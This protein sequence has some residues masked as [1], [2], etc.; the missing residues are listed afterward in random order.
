LTRVSI[1]IPVL[2]KLEFT[3]QCLDRIWRNSGTSI[4]YEVIIIDNGSA[5]ET[6]RFFGDVTT[7]PGKVS[8][9]RNETNL[10]YARANNCAA[11]D[12]AGEYL[13]F[14][15][16]DTLVQEGWLDAMVRTI[17]ADRQVGIVGIKQLFPYTNINYHTGIVFGPDGLP[18]HLYPHLDASLERVNQTREYQAVTGACLLIDRALFAQCGGFD[19]GYVNGYEDVDLCLR[20]R[21]L[22]RKVM[23]CTEAY[24]YHY[25]QISEGRTSADDLNRAKFTARWSGRIKLDRDDYL[26]RDAFG[27]RPSTPS[28]ATPHRLPADAVYF[29]DSLE[30][31]SALTWMNAALADALNR[32]GVPVYVS[33]NRLS[34]TL[35]DDVR[36]R[37]RRCLLSAPPVGGTQVKWSHFWPQHL[38]LELAGNV[39]LELF[40]INYTFGSPHREPWDQWLQ[41]VARS[42]RDKLP[43]SGFCQSVLKQV[44]V[45]E[46]N[47]HV[48]SPGFSPEALQETP[49]RRTADGVRLLSVT[50]SHDLPRYG[51]DRVVE[52]FRLAFKPA[53][54]VTLVLKDYGASSGDRALREMI[55]AAGS[56]HIELVD[57]FTDKRELMR[58]YKSC[59]GFVSAHRGEG[60][61]MKILDA[62]ACGLP[63]ILPLFG[64]PT[65]YCNAENCY[66]VDFSLVPMTEGMDARSLAI[67]NRPQWA[68]V[69]VASLAA[70]M[71]AVCEDLPAAR[72]LG[73]RTQ[74]DVTA[75]FTWDRAAA[76]LVEVAAAICDSRPRPRSPKP[77]ERREQSPYWLGLRVSVVIPTYNRRDKLLACLDALSRQ[78]VLPQEFE[79]LV[80]DDG[81]SDGTRQAVQAQHFPFAL[82]YFYQE[83][84]GPAAARNLGVD[85]AAGELV[86][87]IGDDI[88]ADERL[89]EE[90][91]LA[92]AG[93][94]EPGAAVLGHIDW[95]PSLT[96]TAVM[97]YVCGDAMLQFAYGLIPT[98]ATL[99]Y[100][101]FYT[102]NISLRRAFLLD[103]AA[104]GVRFDSA[105]NH[106]AFEDSEFAFRLMPRGLEIGYAPRA[107]AFHDHWMDYLA[108]C[109]R[110]FR[111]GEM[112]VVF[113]GKHP[114]EDERLRVRAVEQFVGPAKALL[115]SPDLLR[116]LE[117]LDDETD[118]AIA[119]QVGA[120]ETLLALP[121][122]SLRSS[123]TVPVSNLRATLGNL[124]R[125]SF[126]VQR[127]RGKLHQWFVTVH[128]ADLLKAAQ[129]IA[130]VQC[131]LELFRS[132]FEG[133]RMA[134][135]AGE[136][137]FAGGRTPLV[138][139]IRQR[140]RRFLMNTSLPARLLAVDRFIEGRLR[141]SVRT[142]ELVWYRRVRSGL[143]AIVLSKG[144]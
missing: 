14:L 144:T 87:F 43:I 95:H 30:Q 111:A 22:G 92:H 27:N 77:P 46:E 80:I 93:R 101:F 140:T 26:L 31:G 6:P 39:E 2:N 3:R 73:A 127:T 17:A 61:G 15:N 91:L 105:F 143:R 104:A 66:P 12:A 52:A 100:R 110:E 41:S 81:S 117:I 98:L 75:R 112:A 79:V 122:S 35:P 20:V 9:L 126:D 141:A 29:A 125:V 56:L 51:T 123:L 142:R 89:L 120:L 96:S 124:L 106:A 84:Q 58:L 65:D 67:A 34:K 44:G 63:V 133:V 57:R 121:P 74:A 132:Q 10:G 36:V 70:Q 62:M 134:V 71:R 108:F 60:F 40:A 128:N 28:A 18:Q 113:Y 137:P 59:D 21:E 82:R 23:C 85:E 25:G 136:K 114:I 97:D 33:G 38:G 119:A 116:Q 24:I 19:E 94:R 131:K 107:R 103:A 53:D 48:L 69:D 129:T 88:M 1:V 5:D 72:A 118:Q 83:N 76:R 32:L 139:R 45:A 135:T 16:N 47:C 115:D 8:Y 37:L 13:L 138:Q 99:D 4:P 130:A 7:F 78:S 86:L 54:N 11:R 109:R 102:S 68:D 55:A 50:N 42:G 49:P 90:H 64:G